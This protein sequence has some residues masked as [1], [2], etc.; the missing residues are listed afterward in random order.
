MGV[1][2]RMWAVLA[3]VLVLS[4]CASISEEDCVAGNWRQIGFIDGT[5]GRAPDYIERH[6]KACAKVGVT[7]DL[8]AWMAGRADGLQ[9]YCTPASA[10]LVGRRGSSI[11]PYCSATQLTAMRPAFNHGA[12]WWYF[13]QY[14]REL[15]QDLRDV[16]RWMIR[17]AEDD[18]VSY[19]RLTN[20]RW[21][22]ERRIRSA[23]LRQI[24][25]ASWPG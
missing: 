9:T 15:R 16:D 20:E 1:W 23:E 18:A 6:S 22:I 17:L 4:S 14:I 3:G 5:K 21:R 25:Y 13:E 24:R 19:S 10:Y 2:V 11:A 8:T 12:E 7:P